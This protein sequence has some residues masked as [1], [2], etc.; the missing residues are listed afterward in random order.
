ME[1]DI[2]CLLTLIKSNVGYKNKI[3]E[4]TKP[5]KNMQT[6]NKVMVTRGEGVREVEVC[7]G[8]CMVM[9]KN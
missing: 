3:S 8:D 9:D 1:K 2:P 5:N 7:K 6:E 4:Q